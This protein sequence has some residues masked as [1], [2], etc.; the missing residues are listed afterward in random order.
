V[1]SRAVVLTL[2]GIAAV[3]ALVIVAWKNS[4]TPNQ[5]IPDLQSGQSRPKA[6]ARAA[7]RPVARVV[8]RTVGG[9]PSLE[10][11]RGG[12]NG[13]VVFRDVLLPGQPVVRRARSLWLRTNKP[14]SVRITLDRRRVV[15]L[16]GRK[17][18]AYVVTARGV[19]TVTH[20]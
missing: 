16:A 1:E 19:R 18:A 2:L 3:A 11:R 14:A 10:V 6:P 5:N 4:G 7:R 8:F 20:S 12:P 17:P 15:R 9:S 13:P